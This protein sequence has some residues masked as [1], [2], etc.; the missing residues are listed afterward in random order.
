M[1]ANIKRVLIKILPPFC[2]DIYR[3][4]KNYNGRYFSLNDLDK[5]LEKYL[6]ERGG[7]FVELGAND[8]VDQ[9]NTLYFERYKGWNG[10]LVEPVLHNYFSCKENRSLK[11]KIFCNACVSFGYKE[12]FVPIAY[13]NLMT[14]PLIEK[15][16]ISE[17]DKH[18][19]RGRNFLKSHEDVVVFG[20]AAKTL[21]D[22]L[23]E[24]GA[25]ESIDLLSLDVEGAELEVL[26]GVD[27]AKFSF[28][29]MCIECR[30]INRMCSYLHGH[31]YE[32]VEKLSVHDYLFRA[33]K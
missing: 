7:F 10:V 24:S 18:L 14:T 32:L 9:S 3:K 6:P 33:I 21:N 30:D 17:K 2:I 23:I 8:G 1:R 28:R 5:K 31:G 22:I 11:N 25:P 13:A 19:E 12:K 16:D 4:F 27:L 15:S 29:Y 20:A 26:E